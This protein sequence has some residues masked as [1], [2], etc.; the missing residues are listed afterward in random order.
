MRKKVLKTLVFNRLRRASQPIVK[1]SGGGAHT[2][3][4]N[5]VP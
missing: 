3:S 2:R 5:E 1:Y 4:R